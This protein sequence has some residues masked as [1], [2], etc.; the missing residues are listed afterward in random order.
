MAVGADQNLTAPDMAIA[1][2]T[3]SIQCQGNHRPVNM[4]FSHAGDGMGVVVLNR[5]TG[6]A[7]AFEGF[8]IIGAVISRMKIMGH[9]NRVNS[10]NFFHVVNGPGIKRIYLGVVQVPYV[11]T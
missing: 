7:L 4:V 9:E 3:C 6:D 1:A 5:D 8:G 10:Q 11:L 2:K